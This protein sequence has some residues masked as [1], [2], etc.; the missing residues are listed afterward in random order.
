[1]RINTQQCTLFLLFVAFF[2]Q[3][4]GI[5][6]Q[7]APQV[8]AHH[9]P[10]AV[11]RMQVKPLGSVP[12]KQK[13]NL[14]IVLPL[15]NQPQ[16]KNFLKNLYDPS[17]PD[18]R[19]FLSVKDFTDQFGPTEDDYKKVVAFAQANGFTV[20]DAPAN[21]MVVS[22]SG[23]SAQIEK[24]FH[25]AMRNY[26]HPTE[27]RNFF[28]A[29]REPSLALNVSVAHI[30]GLNNFSVPQ[31]LLQKSAATHP[32]DSFRSGG[33]GPGGAYLASDMRQAYYGGK[34]LTGAGQTL[35]LVEFD[36][37]NM[38]DVDLTFSS[39]GQSYSV[40]IKNVLT[41]GASGGPC[42]FGIIYV[43]SPCSDAEQV[44]DIVQAIG[45]APGLS[46][47]RVYIGYLD[48]EIL[49]AIAAEN[50]AKQVSISWGWMP[51]DPDIADVFFEEMARKARVFSL[52]RAIL[53]TI[54]RISLGPIPQRMHM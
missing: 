21:R 51:D 45:M 1:V 40:P 26:R 4:G 29:D 28:S 30:S 8:M 23:T 44:T 10:A 25:V 36:G 14:S 3:I 53:G 19:H 7:P 20:A 35:A 31:P 48:S 54:L 41:G 11:S 37:Y 38:S 49:N 42:Q 39:V 50:L 9:V 12:A 6:A 18:Y 17:N 5:Q 16:L 47:I 22:I 43:G 15:R 52:P 46:E 13:M 24:T 34:A 33:S 2:L 32:L 27:N